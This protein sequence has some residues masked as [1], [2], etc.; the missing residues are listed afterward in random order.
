M[1]DTQ[2]TS[3]C[4]KESLC[5]NAKSEEQCNCTWNYDNGTCVGFAPERR[6]DNYEVEGKAR[7]E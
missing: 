5:R 3:K 7:S 1:V 6:T 2:N 4:P